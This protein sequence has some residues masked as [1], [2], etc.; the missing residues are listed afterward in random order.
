MEFDL[1]E[2]LAIVKMID[3]VI[4]ADGKVHN[5]EINALG[6]LMNSIHFDSNFIVQARNIE[7][8]QGLLILKGM[9]HQKKKA[10]AAIL[11]DV[12]ISDGFVHQKEMSLILGICASI[13]IGKEFE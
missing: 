10:L 4:L 11:E 2:K 5:G 7:T 1:S 8:E 13:G 12:A 6:Q 9:S 3:S